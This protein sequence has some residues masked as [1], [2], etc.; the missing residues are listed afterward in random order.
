MSPA[1]VLSD[2][3]VLVAH[4]DATVRAEIRSL[5]QGVGADVA[6]VTGAAGALRRARRERPHV[7][8]LDDALCRRD[9]LPVL[10]DIVKDPDM[11]GTAVVLMLVDASLDEV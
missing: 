7:L 2:V 3:R 5:L 1:G 9:G 11:L 8:L 10:R 6:T 4:G